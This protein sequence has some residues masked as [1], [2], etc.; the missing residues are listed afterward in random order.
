MRF[1]RVSGLGAEPP[2]QGAKMAVAAA[3]ALMVDT[4]EDAMT[5]PA[6]TP[7]RGLLAAMPS[8][9]VSRPAMA[10]V[11]PFTKKHVAPVVAPVVTY[12]NA[13]DA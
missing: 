7:G 12:V 10:R 1:E 11:V 9:T 3:E 13:P 6:L 5:V 8:M 2:P 4:P